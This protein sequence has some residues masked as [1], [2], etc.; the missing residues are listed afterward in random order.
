MKMT[1]TCL[2]HA[3]L[4]VGELG[5]RLSRTRDPSQ[6]RCEHHSDTFSQRSQLKLFGSTQDQIRVKEHESNVADMIDIYGRRTSAS[7]T[8]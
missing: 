5:S 7:V 2:R 3:E 8:D 4:V 1:L 6:S